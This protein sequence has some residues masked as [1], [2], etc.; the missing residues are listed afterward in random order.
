MAK[1]GKHIFNLIKQTPYEYLKWNKKFVGCIGIQSFFI[2][3]GLTI[4]TKWLQGYFGIVNVR[5][6]LSK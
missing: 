1:N 2:E 5:Y 4:L 3:N 6:Y